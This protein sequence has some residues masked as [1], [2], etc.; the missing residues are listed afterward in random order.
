MTYHDPKLHALSLLKEN[1]DR[2]GLAK[3][4]D[5]ADQ[6]VRSVYEALCKNGSKI[7]TNRTNG[8]PKILSEPW[9]PN[10]EPSNSTRRTIARQDTLR[11]RT[12]EE[13]ILRLM[14]TTSDIGLLDPKLLS[15]AN[16]DRL[17]DGHVQ[18]VLY[19]AD[20]PIFSQRIRKLVGNGTRS[21]G[22]IRDAYVTPLALLLL[23]SEPG[24][25]ATGRGHATSYWLQTS[26]LAE[27]FIER[28]YARIID[29]WSSRVA[30]G[31]VVSTKPS[32]EKPR[33]RLEK[34]S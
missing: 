3:E 2:F 32:D 20:S 29:E 9:W 8:L 19:E 23:L 7:D 15:N 25:A 17:L 28:C 6:A 24:I 1:R 10:V 34:E 22:A 18:A 5:L 31:G 12:W 30:A 4:R 14:H 13:G 16:I 11:W 33:D 27:A 26:Y 21:T